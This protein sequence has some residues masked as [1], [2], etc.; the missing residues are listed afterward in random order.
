MKNNIMQHDEQNCT[1]LR[2]I[3]DDIIYTNVRL[4]KGMSQRSLEHCVKLIQKR[5]FIYLDTECLFTNLFLK[6]LKI[7]FAKIILIYLGT[8]CI[9]SH[10]IHVCIIN[11]IVLFDNDVN[12]WDNN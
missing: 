6:K 10:H 3:D 8:L 7:I 12:M 11:Y 9:N 5:S 4:A 2:K 1:Q